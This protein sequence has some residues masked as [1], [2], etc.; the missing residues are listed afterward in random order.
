MTDPQSCPLTPQAAGLA[1]HSLEPDEEM[2]VLLHVPHCPECS[3][4]LAESELV[5]AR[6]GASVEQVDPPAD[7]RTRILAAAAADTPRPAAD[8]PTPPTRSDGRHRRQSTGPTGRVDVTGPPRGRRRGRARLL[9]VAAAL[10]ALVAIGGL[11]VR[12]AQ[13]Q[14]E[15]DAAAARAQAL[16]ELVQHLAQPHAVLA[17]DDGTTVAAVVLADGQRQVYTV[18]LPANAAD[19]QYVLWGVKG[20]TPQALGSFD[21]TRAGQGLQTVGSATPD[22]YQ[23]YAISLEPGRTLPSTPTDVIAKGA[24]RA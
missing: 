18:D 4:V 3:A 19:Q 15:R 23:A 14:S 17:R 2:S 8:D 12:T 6:L 10:V 9:A 24:L 11:G 1:F 20:G 16:T 5:L 13:L 21:V 7:L 22:T